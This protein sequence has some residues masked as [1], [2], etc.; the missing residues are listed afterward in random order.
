MRKTKL[1]K[2][3]TQQQTSNTQMRSP[4]CVTK[5]CCSVLL[6]CCCA[7]NENTTNT[8][9]NSKNSTFARK[10]K[11]CQIHVRSSRLLLC[12]WPLFRVWLKQSTLNS[13]C[14]SLLLCCSRIHFATLVIFIYFFN[15]F[16]LQFVGANSTLLAQNF[17]CL[18]LARALRPLKKARPKLQTQIQAE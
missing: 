13:F 9:R 18:S 1:N 3:R 4:F 14:V 11:L 10:T 16:C 7:D 17:V 12:F 5:I 6:L 2:T 8:K 15:N